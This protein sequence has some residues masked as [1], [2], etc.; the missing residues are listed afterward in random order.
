MKSIDRGKSLL[1]ERGTTTQ[2]VEVYLAFQVLVPE[3]PRP[4]S[5]GPTSSRLRYLR[6]ENQ[7][8]V[9]EYTVQLTQ[10]VA[11][12]ESVPV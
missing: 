8:A 9:P 1:D 5:E 10:L 2:M 11:V 6:R 7:D 12:T 4:L 3:R